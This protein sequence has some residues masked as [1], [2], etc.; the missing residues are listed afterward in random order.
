[1]ARNWWIWRK[2]AEN[3]LNLLKLM[4]FF[5]YGC[6]WLEMAKTA[7]MA[8]NGSKLVDMGGHG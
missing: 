6:K 4:L 3:G 2:T 1:M 8:V 5:G 7:G